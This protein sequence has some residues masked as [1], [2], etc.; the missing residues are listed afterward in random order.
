MNRAGQSRPYIVRSGSFWYS[1]DSPFSYNSEGD[2]SLAF[3]DLL[4]DFF[5]MPHQE[6]RKALVRLEDISVDDEID[7][8]R[9]VADY[10][11]ESAH[12]ISDLSDPDLQETREIIRKST[13]RIGPAFVRTIKYMVSKGG[14]VVLHGVY[15]QYRGRSGDDYEFWDEQGHKADTGRFAAI[16]RAEAAAGAGRVFQK[17]NLSCY[18]GNAPLRRFGTGLR[19]HRTLLQHILRARAFDEQFRFRVITF[20]IPPSTGSAALSSRRVLDT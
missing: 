10:L 16:G 15:H 4:H 6:E 12:S 14:L 8:L 13:F 5:Q 20:P 19:D 3:C 17:R 7:D 9:N 18:L 11:Y 1:A 2:R